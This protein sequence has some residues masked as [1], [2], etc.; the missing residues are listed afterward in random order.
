MPRKGENIYKRKDQ[1]WEGRYIRAHRED[2]SAHY[3]YCYGKTY[4]EVKQKMI[5][6]QSELKSKRNT[7]SHD[8][9]PLFSEFCAS[10]LRS[11]STRVK[12][13]TYIK[14]GSI[15]DKY[16][17]PNFGNSRIG[18]ISTSVADAFRQ[19]LLSVNGLAPKT[20]RDILTILKAVLEYAAR[21]LPDVTLGVEIQ[22]P[23]GA[24]QEIRVLSQQEQ[25]RFVR[26]LIKD[27]DRYKFGVLLTLMTGL[28]IGELCA[29]RWKD[30]LL[31]EKA[32]CVNATMQRVAD[33][34]K[35][36]SSKTKIVITDPKSSCSAR[37]IP[38]TDQALALCQRFCCREADAFLLTGQADRFS[39]PR[40]MQ[41]KLQR[42]TADC[43]L[44][45]VH[46]HTL[47]HTFATRCV[48]VDFEIKS[49]SQIMGH[50]SPKITLERYV[51]PSL[52]LMH[53]NM[54]KLSVSGL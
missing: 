45:D 9:Q 20:V 1:R 18:Q 39:E 47:R 33:Y 13:S 42:Y 12:E 6:A 27:M 4:R 29:L 52:Q 11:V 41:Y 2:G 37:I 40:A 49:L 26:Y 44:Q 14:Y 15:L 7:V 21:Q 28:R 53:E 38:L 48:E 25:E 31:D 10:W 50:S 34:R 16:L 51:H 17:I 32:I 3:G 23:K 43:G 24:R 19:E 5:T 54:S 22:Y 30:I 36:G 35:S 46:F 8:A